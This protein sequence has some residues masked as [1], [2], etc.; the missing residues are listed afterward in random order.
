MPSHY[1]EEIAGMDAQ[2]I[3]RKRSFDEY[4]ADDPG[5]LFS[6]D[7][8][9]EGM[10][11]DPEQSPYGIT[12]YELNIPR[13]GLSG[14]FSRTGEGRSVYDKGPVGRAQVEPTTE[15]R[16]D[17]IRYTQPDTLRADDAG[18]DAFDAANVASLMGEGRGPDA[19]VL[20]Q[21][22]SR[23]DDIIGNNLGSIY[24]G[25]AKGLGFKGGTIAA[26]ASLLGFNPMQIASASPQILAALV[27]NPMTMGAVFGKGLDA[28]L[29]RDSAQQDIG[30]MQ[31][32]L[33]LN[34]DFTQGP[35]AIGVTTGQMGINAARDY[36]ANRSRMG[37]TGS[38]MD[39]LGLSQNAAMN[40]DA[41]EE[42]VFNNPELAGQIMSGRA[43]PG[44]QEYQDYQDS[45]GQAMAAQNAAGGLGVGG[46]QVAAAQAG[47]FGLR[48]FGT[49]SIE[50]RLQGSLGTYDPVT[51]AYSQ[52]GQFDPSQ[53]GNISAEID[54]AER[55]MFE[56]RARA[57]TD[58]TFA[59]LRAQRGGGGVSDTSG[60]SDFDVAGE[61]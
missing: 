17:T 15:T 9:L 16:P 14:R 46:A 52:G 48:G 21:F 54:A 51:G 34:P 22:G 55:A 33:D 36:A 19:D 38:M 25:L 41:A 50:D 27:A 2:D 12:Q 44:A 45:L 10:L 60:V 3:T 56:A 13:Y 32:A 23:V 58:S 24:G 26:Q 53:F 18:A 28:A 37:I 6:K 4:L 7:L 1:D 61:L 35:G 20:G 5:T 49:Q 47:G 57:N 43:I 31:N 8:A 42:A 39:A 40:L 30:A 29:D 59:D 11:V